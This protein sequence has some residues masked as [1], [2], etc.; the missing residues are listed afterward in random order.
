MDVIKQ[1]LTEA[2]PRYL[3]ALPIPDDFAGFAELSSQEWIALAPVLL[4]VFGLV[5]L[6]VEGL[7]GGSGSKRINTTIKLKE[8]KVVDSE[9]TSAIAKAKDGK[10]VYC[11]C[12][13]SKTFPY[14]DKSHVEH[15]A[16]TG[17]NV[18]PLVIKA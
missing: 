6:I 16:A 3:K 13:K 15:N 9:A 5:F 17:D 1:S 14:C 7:F 8:E 2:L 18:G 10:K 11:R 12:W 4:F